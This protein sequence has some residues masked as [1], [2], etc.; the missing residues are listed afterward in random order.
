[1]DSGDTAFVLVCA[2]LVFIMTPGLGFFYGGLGRRKNVINNIM[3]VT[4]IMGLGIV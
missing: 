1:M 3:A 2:A 4:F